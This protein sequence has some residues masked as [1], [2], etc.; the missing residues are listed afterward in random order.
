MCITWL[1]ILKNIGKTARRYFDLQTLAQQGFPDQN[2]QQLVT[3][4]L[5]VLVLE[6]KH[7]FL[8]QQ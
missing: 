7:N 2:T 6:L 4:F 8:S 5:E 1:Q 3:F